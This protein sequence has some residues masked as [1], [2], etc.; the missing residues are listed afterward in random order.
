MSALRLSE[1]KCIGYSGTLFIIKLTLVNNVFVFKK[2]HRNF[3]NKRQIIF[4]PYMT[5]N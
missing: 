2:I 3:K 4:D 5:L 1:N